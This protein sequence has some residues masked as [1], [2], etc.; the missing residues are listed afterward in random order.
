MGGS[1]K[2]MNDKRIPFGF[3]IKEKA[4]DRQK[5]RYVNLF[6][7]GGATFS[8]R[9]MDVEDNYA[10]LNPFQ[11]NVFTKEGDFE[12]KFVREEELVCLASIIGVE[13]TTEESLIGSC[14]YVDTMQAKANDKEKN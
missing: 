5:G 10:V 8:G 13:P 9:L 1:K 3:R 7:Q 12:R 6:T 14:R 4:L 11:A 2:K